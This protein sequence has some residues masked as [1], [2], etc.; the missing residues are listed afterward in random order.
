MG[1]NKL[2]R[3]E[4]EGMEYI[5]VTGL[6]G[7]GKTQTTHVLEDLGYYCIDN[8]PAELLSAF[9]DLTL[10]NSD[11]LSKVALVMDIR[12]GKFFDNIRAA[13]QSVEN[14][15]FICKILYLEADKDVLI[16]RFKEA[17]RTHPLDPTDT[18]E[19]CIIREN[20]ILAEIRN[21][22][23]YIINTSRM[24][25]S[26]LKNAIIESLEGDFDSDSVM[27]TLMSFGFKKGIPLDS[28]MVFDLR[29]LPNPYYQEKL[30]ELNGN[31]QDV[32][33][34]VMSFDDSQDYYRKIKDMV[35][36]V[37]GQCVKEARSQ[38]FISIGCTGGQHR[39]VTFVN[40]LAAELIKEGF[41]ASINHR[42]LKDTNL[43]MR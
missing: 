27:I 11:D 21:D 35:V 18:L 41:N 22:A 33:D 3:R 7:A 2:K 34:F 15:G 1:T 31:D 43:L 23:C 42:D 25:H 30:R 8:L 40:L 10:R 20:E 6:S 26:Q 28:D 39:S 24:N 29:F 14:Q 9:T 32:R 38:L 5:I 13:L 17:K 12:G 37:I 36:F 4:I 19:N 16:K